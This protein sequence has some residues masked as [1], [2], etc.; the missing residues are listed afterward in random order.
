MGIESDHLVYEYLSRVGDLAAQRQLSSG[1]RMRL[2]S[3]LR[4]E[5][6]RR[7]AKYEPDTT[8]AVRGI[9]ERIGTPEEVLDTVGAAA[10]GATGPAVIPAVPTVP[11][12]PAQR[13]PEEL[14]RNAPRNAPQN[15]PQ[16]VPPHLAG[17]DELG[18]SGG[19]EPDWWSLSPG[20]SGR[21]RGPQVEGFAGGIEIPDLFGEEAE[22]ERAAKEKRE[23]AQ[24]PAAG[25]AAAAGGLVRFLRD[26]REKKR[27]AAPEG[28]PR[29]RPHAFLVLA[30]VLLLAGALTGYWPLLGAG[31]LVAYASRVLGPRE[32]KWV[33][34]GLPAA[35]FTLA[36]LWLWG[37][38]AG[39]WGT[40]IPSDQVGPA[41]Q[42]LWPTL[43]RTA[44]AT[45]AAYL[46]WRSRRR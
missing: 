37:R 35:V 18:P 45:T 8:A 40:P 10:R 21:G 42:S 28:E 32:R 2:V 41:F 24:D 30:A 9:L 44:G 33:L 6:D 16:N 19:A 13:A 29:P 17:L 38:A 7:R 12:V 22:E 43:A 15:A 5:I 20:G 25:P 34:L 31:A 27:A 26:R 23:A 39:N 11:A 46:L 4:D 36:M 14:P 1:D 3:G